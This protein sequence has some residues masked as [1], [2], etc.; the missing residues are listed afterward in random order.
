MKKL[1]ITVLALLALGFYNQNA[2]A[3]QDAQFTQYM[4]NTLS[5]NPAYAGARDVFSFVG[6]YR[7]Q[8]VGLEGAP[9]SFTASAHSPVGKKVGLGLNITRDE[10]FI[11]QETYIDIDFSYTLDVSEEGK[12]AL[13]LKGGAHLLDIDTAR[14][15]N[16]AFNPGD[17]EAQINIDN[18][19]SPQIGAGLYYYT[20]KFYLGLSVPNFIETE[21]F[22]ESSNSNNSSAT[23][24][25]RVNYYLMS[26][27]A[28]DVTDNLVFKPAVLFKMV[29][30]APLQADVSANFLIHDKLTLGAAYRWSAALSGL[31]GF[32]VTDQIM[33]GFAYDRET[34]E[35]QQYNDGSYEVFLR[36]ELF[37]RNK[38]LI[39]PRFF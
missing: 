7:S 33:I 24:K 23:A 2:S 6:L 3:Q 28:F 38:R 11:A 36:F 8:W 37:N 21:H 35:L 14:L 29:Q 10:I 22:D 15:N 13:G 17:P 31:L 9:R 5:I 32:Q 1:Y 25:E 34:T 20:Q 30:G 27:Y 4:Y 12:L 18:R 39:S 19:L 26:G 16:G